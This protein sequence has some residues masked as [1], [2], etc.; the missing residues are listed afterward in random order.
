M[1]SSRDN[2]FTLVELLVVIAII[3]VLVAMLLPAVQ[4]AREAARRNSCVN[5]LK[6][7]GLS[8]QMYHDTRKHFPPG[9]LSW[10]QRG[11]SWAFRLLPYL[12]L[13]NIH[14][15]FDPRE[16][17]FDEANAQA[18]RTPVDTF[19]CPS[20][21]S[22]A[23]DR[24]FDNNDQAPVVQGV[25][26]GGDY[27]ANTGLDHLYGTPG[28]PIPPEDPATIVGPIHSYSRVKDRHVTDGLSQ[29]LAIGE[30]HIPNDLDVPPEQEHQM[31]GDT[32]FFAADRPTTIFADTGDGIASGR[33][34]KSDQKFGSEHNQIV[35]FVFLDGHVTGISTDIELLTLQHLSIISDG[36]VI[37]SAAL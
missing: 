21:R 20:R 29:T 8:V 6:Q 4:A 37:D 13:D 27:A 3:G 35:N 24:D 1:R 34:D 17:V 32:A 12:E 30:R 22:P 36:Q 16:P 14:R 33:E 9:R 31:A 18:M 11:E 5:N 28:T 7:I 26:A 2:G 19:V 10:Q 15:S 23:A 25:A